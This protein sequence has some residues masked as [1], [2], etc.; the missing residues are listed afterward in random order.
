MTIGE[1]RVNDYLLWIRTPG[2]PGLR[3]VP[4]S[5]HRKFD[6]RLKIT[7]AVEAPAQKLKYPLLRKVGAAFRT[8]ETACRP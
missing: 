5:E 7:I 1:T 8:P 6:R 2:K 3:K 4:R